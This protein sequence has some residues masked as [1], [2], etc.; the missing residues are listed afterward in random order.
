MKREEEEEEEKSR[1]GAIIGL[2][3][4]TCLPDSAGITMS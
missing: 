1:Q 3:Q 4:N 2:Q